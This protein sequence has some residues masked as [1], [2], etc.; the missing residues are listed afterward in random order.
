M[1]NLDRQPERLRWMERGLAAAR[2]PFRRVRAVDGGRLSPDFVARIT[3]GHAHKLTRFDVAVVMGHRKAWRALLRS[4]TRHCV[5]LEDDVHF[6]Q[7]FAD[8]LA[9]LEAGAASFDIVKLES[10]G[11]RVLVDVGGGRTVAGRRLC[12]L[13]SAYMG[14]AGYVVN[15]KA[16]ATLLRMTRSMAVPIDW[17]LFADPY[18][19]GNGLVVLQTMPGIVAQE[20]HLRRGADAA[21]LRSFRPPRTEGVDRARRAGPA[22]KILREIARPFRQFGPAW[23][24]RRMRRTEPG[25]RWG[26]IGFE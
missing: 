20:E 1:I 16:A 25:L 14:A 23:A 7:G 6:G 19:T 8:L 3:A 21:H 13:R 15:R 11:E 26:R 9:A 2:V 17:F 5:V 4:R 22:R 24:R 10:V 12:R 18:L